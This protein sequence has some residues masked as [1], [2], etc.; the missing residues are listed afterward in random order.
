MKPT[1]CPAKA[2]RKKKGS[3]KCEIRG[4]ERKRKGTVKAYVSLLKPKTKF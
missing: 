4:E 3:K 1:N 2:K